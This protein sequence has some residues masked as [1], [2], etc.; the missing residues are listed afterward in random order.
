MEMV[1]VVDKN[2]EVLSQISKDEA[3]QKGLL[4]RCIVSQVID[5]SGL[6]TLVKQADDR[7]DPGQYVS[8]VGG[9]MQAGE[10][11][12]DALKREAMEEMGIR[13]F[14][15]KRVGQAIFNREVIG[16]K[17]NHF[18][19]L[20]KIYSD[21]PPT[22]NHESVSFE[23]FSFAQLQQKLKTDPTKFGKAFHFVFETIY[24]LEST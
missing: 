14:T 3:H 12:E 11:E 10:S 16:R 1:D 21:Q 2:N 5:S 4:H 19:I 8:P 13:L 22:L 15:F 23:K 6:W 18:F 20:Y 24:S 7:Q 9:H 17:E